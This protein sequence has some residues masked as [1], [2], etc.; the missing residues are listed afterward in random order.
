MYGFDVKFVNG[1]G[2][3]HGILLLSWANKLAVSLYAIQYVKLLTS[4]IFLLIKDL[5]CKM[6]CKRKKDWLTQSVWAKN[7]HAWY[8]YSELID[9]SCR[10]ESPAL[11][12][13]AFEERT[14]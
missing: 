1:G 5:I 2:Y 11:W 6:D 8:L 3:S 13:A 10:E 4:T 14:I 9:L 7:V 12:L